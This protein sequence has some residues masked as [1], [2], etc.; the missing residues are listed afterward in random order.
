MVKVYD[1]SVVGSSSLKSSRCLNS[2]FH[3]KPQPL[4]KFGGGMCPRMKMQPFKTNDMK[5]DLTKMSAAV[6]IYGDSLYTES[7]VLGTISN[8]DYTLEPDGKTLKI[9]VG[10]GV[11]YARIKQSVL[12]AGID[13]ETKVF[14]IQEMVAKRD[15][16]GISDANRPWSVTAGEVRLFAY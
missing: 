11:L 16:N 14:T 7:T 12:D 15:A 5:L 10:H 4:L 3:L 6:K 9:D 13:F 2:G 8:G 1:T